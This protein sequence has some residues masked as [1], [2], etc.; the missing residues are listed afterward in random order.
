[1]AALASLDSA[2]IR[3]A[4]AHAA[5]VGAPSPAFTYNAIVKVMW[6]LYFRSAN[7]GVGKCALHLL[8]LEDQ[9]LLVDWDLRLVLDLGLQVG[10]A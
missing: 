2:H 8:A 9:T 7:G 1:M 4:R 5:S 10:D 3:R 6:R